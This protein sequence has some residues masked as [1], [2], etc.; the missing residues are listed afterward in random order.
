MSEILAD[1]TEAMASRPWQLKVADRITAALERDKVVILDAPTGS[2]KTLIAL[3]VLW[4]QINSY[5]QRG[6]VAV[7]TIN[8]MSPYSRDIQRFFKDK[9]TLSYLLGK[10]R[11][12]RRVE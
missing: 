7:R 8:E 12:W 6:L 11:T 2:G 3:R 5:K 10:S 1:V 9:I 4:H